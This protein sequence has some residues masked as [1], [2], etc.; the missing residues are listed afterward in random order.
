MGADGL[1]ALVEAL[2]QQGYRVVGP[3]VRD[4][5][6]VLDEI[7]SADELPHGWTAQHEAATYRVE[8]REDDAVFGWAVGP[9]SW[10]QEL[11][12]SRVRL[13]RSAGAASAGAPERIH[14]RHPRAFILAT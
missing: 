11:L 12:P 10:K 2:R 14:S 1:T 3:T 13:F 6:I 5:A 8:R 9:H 4:G 7:S